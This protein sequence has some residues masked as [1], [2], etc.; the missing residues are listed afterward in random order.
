MQPSEL[1][2]ITVVV[3]LSSYFAKNREQIS[4]WTGG[5]IPAFAISAVMC[6]PIILQPNLSMVLCIMITTLYHAVCLRGEQKAFDDT[7]LGGPGGRGG[8]D[9]HRA[10]PPENACS[11][12]LDP[13]SDAQG[14]SWQLIQ[15]YS[16]IGSGGLFGKG[17]GMSPRELLFL[18][19]EE[20]D[21][22]LFPSSPRSCGLGRRA[23]CHRRLYVF[24]IWR[25]MRV[26]L[27]CPNTFGSN[28]AMGITAMIAVQVA[29]NIGVVTGSIPPAGQTP[30]V[31]LPPARAH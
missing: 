30:A 11:C 12:F 10:V 15:S 20:S 2:K 27:T 9:H 25:G 13:S 21:F 16:A 17:L 28:L 1:C 8:A 23:I 14:D 19:M 18:P 26:A 5:I 7:M 29:I 24:L 4:T 22:L 31:C 6:I 3:L